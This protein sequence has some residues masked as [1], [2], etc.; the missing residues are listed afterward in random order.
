M[1]KNIKKKKVVVIG[2]GNVGSSYAFLMVSESNI[3]QIAIISRRYELVNS[4]VEDLSH[5]TAFMKSSVKV[6][7]GD[8]T[9]CS[10]ADIILIAASA[11][12]KSVNKRSELLDANAKIFN[13]I[14]KKALANNF[15]GIFIIAS[16]PVD[17][18]SYFT[19]KLSGFP[20]EKVI[21]SGT[22]I[23]S[24]RFKF[25][26]SEIYNVSPTEIQAMVIGEHGDSQV[27]LW[28]K[29]NISGLMLNNLISEKYQHLED[30]TT[31][32]R[33]V[34]NEIMKGKGNT[35]YGIAKALV[36]ITN[37]IINN[38]STILTVSSLLE[39]EYGYH[40]VYSG[41]P[42]L[43]NENGAQKIIDLPLNETESENLK[44]SISNLKKSQSK[45][46]SFFEED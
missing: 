46:S 7:V 9:D 31:Y 10:D 19:K 36:E 12:M 17:T 37:A 20:K 11:S 3:D 34:G 44:S 42:T 13:S 21:G 25:K 38:E 24:A 14:I 27:P 16:N 33:E 30:I 40:D 32:T 43:I 8:Y 29:A 2:N 6:K 5:M 22:I 18:L 35:S 39:G 28:S 41:A 1:G 23:D 4:N 26:L 15:Q 45:I